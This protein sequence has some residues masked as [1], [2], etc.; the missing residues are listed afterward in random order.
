MYFF[1][2]KRTFLKN[3]FIFFIYIE[4]RINIIWR[5]AV[6]WCAILYL[7]ILQNFEKQGFKTQNIHKLKLWYDILRFT[8]NVCLFLYIST[9]G[10]LN[11]L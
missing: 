10:W 4:R 2:F 3:Y 7:S 5:I 6:L 8:N 11:V 1:I 9:K